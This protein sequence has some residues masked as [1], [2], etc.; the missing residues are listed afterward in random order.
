MAV[1]LTKE[2]LNKEPGLKKTLKPSVIVFLSQ[3]TTQRLLEN[4]IS[5]RVI[6]DYETPSLHGSVKI[7]QSS[8]QKHSN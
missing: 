8:A 3:K 1:S 2:S 5:F 4:C 7:G 6:S